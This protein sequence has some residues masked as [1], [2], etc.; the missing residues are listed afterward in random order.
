[1]S[2]VKE[3]QIKR[4]PGYNACQILRT[5]IYVAIYLNNNFVKRKYCYFRNIKFPMHYNNSSQFCKLLI[6]IKHT[7][8]E[9]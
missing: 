1:M 6:F 8:K 3:K 7:F 2:F 9:D 4:I 5:R